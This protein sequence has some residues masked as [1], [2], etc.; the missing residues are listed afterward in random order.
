MEAL[1][2]TNLTRAVE[3]GANCYAIQLANKT[4]ILD[5]GLHPKLEGEAALPHHGLIADDSVEAIILSHAHH[6]HVGSLPVL[7][8]RHPRAPVFMTEATRQ[9]SDV[10]LHNS[11][12]VMTKK[13]DEGIPAYPLFTHR[14]VELCTKRWRA[15]P[16]AQRFDLGGDRLSAGETADITCEFFDAG[17]I[18]GSA[19]TLIRA[20]GRTIFYTGDVNFDDQ[21]LMQSARFPLEQI[22]VLIMETTRGDHGTPDGFSRAAEEQRLARTINEVF[23]RGGAVLLPLFALGKTQELLA[24]FFG[25]RKRG[26]LK[27]DCPIYIGGL[28]AKLTE[29]HDKLAGRTPRQH[30][31]LQLLDEVAP[32]VLSGQ[33]AGELPAKGGRI[34]ALSSGMM[35][36]KTL[37]N[38]FARQF[39]SDPVQS[40]IFVGYADPQS[41]AGKIRNAHLGDIVQLAADIP[42]Q[43]LRC[44]V[45]K[46]NFS[47][48]ASRE[49]LRAYVNK[50]RPKTVVLVHGDMSSV[51]WFREALTGDLPESRIVTPTPGVS[52]EL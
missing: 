43:P 4:V 26:L 20:N 23:A 48:H 32:F 25:F 1:T 19:G 2:F 50:I 12:N 52:L 39:L 42:P 9:L 47:G 40:L 24:M 10:M 7:M 29:I 3:I 15:A 28:S 30:A 16:L 14:E 21:T 27:R 45:E 33:Q 31:D 22:D 36:E 13:R 51:E 35:T 44:D 49:S 37:S 11:V 18:L 38:T 46:F 6:D 41:P 17:H 34:Y 8:R 5:S